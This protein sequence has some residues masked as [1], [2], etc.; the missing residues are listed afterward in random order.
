MTHFFTYQIYRKTWAFP[1]DMK[2]VSKM[3]LTREVLG[4]KIN[5]KDATGLAAGSPYL[6]KEIAVQVWL[7]GRLFL[8]V[9]SIVS[10]ITGK[11]IT[12]H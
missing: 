10:L 3:N 8:C 1:L 9:L 5:K 4:D 2:Q 12:K 6:A 7:P 11:S